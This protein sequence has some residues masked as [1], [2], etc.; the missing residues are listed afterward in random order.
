ML[1]YL[2]ASTNRCVKNSRPPVSGFLGLHNL[3]RMNTSGIQRRP[4]LKIS[5]FFHKVENLKADVMKIIIVVNYFHESTPS[6]IFDRVPNMPGFWICQSSEYIRVL[7]MPRFW[8][9]HGFEYASGSVYQGS[10]YARVT[11]GSKYPYPRICLNMYEYARICVNIPT[12]AWIAF[13]LNFLIV[14]PLNCFLEETKFDF[15]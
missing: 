9:Y 6:Q 15:F 8:I 13:V 7:N 4:V 10:K 5:Y 1:I 11:E 3:H 14:I 12:S 2:N